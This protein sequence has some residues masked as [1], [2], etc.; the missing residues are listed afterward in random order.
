MDK[1]KL[2]LVYT[3]GNTTVMELDEEHHSTGRVVDT[4]EDD[5][6]TGYAIYENIGTEEAPDWAEWGYYDQDFE[7]AKE[8]FN[9][10]KEK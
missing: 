6:T 10:L 7:K 4:Y 9:K 5:G 1:Y 8:M 2:C 3:T